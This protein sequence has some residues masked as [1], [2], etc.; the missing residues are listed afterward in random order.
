MATFTNQATLSYRDITVS[1][2]ITTGELAEDLTAAKTA[3][4]PTYAAG[5]TL[6]Y[7]ISLV[8]EGSASLA[9]LSITDDLGGYVFG[10]GTVYPLAYVD[11]SVRCFADGVLQANGQTVTTDDGKTATPFNETVDYLLGMGGSQGQPFS[12]ENDLIK[13]DEGMS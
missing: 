3:V 9:D 6:T 8:N 7:V 5:D 11:G 10:G 4:I 2:N 12:G 1:S 13:D